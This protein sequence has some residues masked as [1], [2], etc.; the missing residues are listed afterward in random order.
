MR[1][2]IYSVRPTFSPTIEAETK[3]WAD[4]V[5]AATDRQ[6]FG[7]LVEGSIKLAVGSCVADVLNI[8]G[9]VTGVL[10]FTVNKFGV[11]DLDFALNVQ[12]D[13]RYCAGIRS[14]D[15]CG[16]TLCRRHRVSWYMC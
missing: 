8:T 2:R 16:A 14:F 3:P 13:E 6:N 5:A 1:T 7:A 4:T 9:E 15:R 12:V 11:G 10:P